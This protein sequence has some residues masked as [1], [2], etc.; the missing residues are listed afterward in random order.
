MWQRMM[1]V[2][3]L[4]T[5]AAVVALDGAPPK[6]SLPSETRAVQAGGASG[7]AAGKKDQDIS[8]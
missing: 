2:W 7:D 3:L 5:A 4:G 1:R 8:T 6:P